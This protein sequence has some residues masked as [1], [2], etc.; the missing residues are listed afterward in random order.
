MTISFN[1]GV[2]S[3]ARYDKFTATLSN[4]TGDDA[5]VNTVADAISGT[6]DEN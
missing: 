6:V 4:G 5:T 2:S 1:Y 3:E